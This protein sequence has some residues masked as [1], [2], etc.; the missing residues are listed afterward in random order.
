MAQVHPSAVIDAQ[1]ELAGDVVVGP[2][3]VLDGPV[4]I[5]P[6]TRLIGHVHLVGPVTIGRGN[7]IYPFACIG[8]EPQDRKFDRGSSPS[9]GVVIGDNNLIRESVTIHRATSVEHPT[10]VGDDNMLMTNAHLGHDVTVGSGCTLASGALIAG[11]ARLDDQVNVAGNSAIHQFCHLGRLSFVGGVSAVSKDVLPFALTSGLNSVM[12]V[13]V[14]GLRRSGVGRAAIDAVNAAYR[15]IY[16]DGHTLPTAREAVA[17]Q[18]QQCRAGGD[19]QAADLLDELRTF[20][21]QSQRGIVPHAMMNQRH[22]MQ[23]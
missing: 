5:G 6:G 9:A 21:E 4:R 18:A 19:T 15:T 23:R 22:G 2:G 7:T 12:G 20:L 16:L 17:A 8:F 11:H 3:C 13:N 14:V 1:A 10:R